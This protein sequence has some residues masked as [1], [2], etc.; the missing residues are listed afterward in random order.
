[1]NDVNRTTEALGGAAA[2]AVAA[3]LLREAGS[4]ARAQG[5]LLSGIEA[6]WADWIKRRREAVD[7]A[8]RSLQEMCACRSVGDLARIQQEWLA[9]AMHRAACDAAAMASGA[10]AMT[11]LAAGETAGAAAPSRMPQARGGRPASSR[12]REAAEPQREAAE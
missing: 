1:M 11:R 10:V 12:E 2:N 9:G 4:W 8:A 3:S 6:I 7:A 5:A